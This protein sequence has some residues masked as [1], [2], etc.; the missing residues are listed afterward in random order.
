MNL[1]DQDTPGT[2]IRGDRVLPVRPFCGRYTWSEHNTWHFLQG[3][4]YHGQFTYR[5]LGT[6]IMMCKSVTMAHTSADT[7]TRAL[8]VL[9]SLQLNYSKAEAT[10]AEE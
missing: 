2:A 9:L 3:Y 8:S 10:D 1:S 6:T 5:P 7:F 4:R